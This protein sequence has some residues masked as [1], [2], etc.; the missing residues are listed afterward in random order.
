MAVPSMIKDKTGAILF[1]GTFFSAVREY[2]DKQKPQGSA[3]LS[4]SRISTYILYK[5]SI[6][7][8]S[9]RCII[10]ININLLE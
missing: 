6:W 10:S 8:K 1:A 3:R 9:S 5:R 7:Q 4:E 2:A